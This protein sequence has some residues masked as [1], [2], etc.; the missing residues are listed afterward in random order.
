MGLGRHTVWS[1]WSRGLGG[2]CRSLLDRVHRF[3]RLLNFFSLST[4]QV[5]FSGLRLL[6]S[7]RR[8][9][10]KL[11]R[12]LI[13]LRLLLRLH[14]VRP[15]VANRVH[16]LLGNDQPR[17]HWVIVGVGEDPIRG[18]G[19]RESAI[20]SACVLMRGRLRRPCLTLG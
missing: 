12:Q 16:L 20:H 14:L 3:L 9:L 1:C 18:I 7:L 4:L 5:L 6:L 8:L 17:W 15:R 2:C 11:R 10:L 13:L 19:D